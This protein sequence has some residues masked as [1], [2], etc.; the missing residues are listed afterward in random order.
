MIPR[1][2]RCNGASR[3]GRFEGLLVVGALGLG[4]AA[5]GAGFETV[6]TLPKAARHPAGADIDPTPKLPPSTRRGDTESGLV[7]LETP[8][9]PAQAR[10]VIAAF[11]RAIVSESPSAIQ[12]T[13]A[14]SATMQE[15]ARRENAQSAW[16]SRFTR[17]DYRSLAG[18]RLY[19]ESEIRMREDQRDLWVGVPVEVAWGSRPRLLGET[20]TFRLVPRG[21]GWAIAEI[22][23]E[24][25]TP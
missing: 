20:F 17:F 1:S 24:F 10:D 23:E 16:A 8:A 5:Q 9:D 25:R 12:A 2:S 3:A 21:A 4:C 22:V 6:T 11:F 19:R 18:E 14:A 15:G 7:V 13:L